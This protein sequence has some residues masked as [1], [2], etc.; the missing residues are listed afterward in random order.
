MNW[1]Q[2]SFWKRKD[3]FK[4][5]KQILDNNNLYETRESV[6]EYRKSLKVTETNNEHDKPLIKR[7]INKFQKR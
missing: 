6:L 5:L 3:L 7:F 4:D 2:H 1:R